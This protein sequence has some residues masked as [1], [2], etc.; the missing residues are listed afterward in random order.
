ML[1][2]KLPT[3]ELQYEWHELNHEHKILPLTSQPFTCSLVG[4]SPMTRQTIVGLLS[5]DRRVMLSVY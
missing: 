4:L 2:Q 1:Q 5:T 3:F